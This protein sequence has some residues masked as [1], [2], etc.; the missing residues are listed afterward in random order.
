M[1]KLN[2]IIIIIGGCSMENII[3]EHY[4]T[5]VRKGL[6]QKYIESKCIEEFAEKFNNKLI[7]TLLYDLQDRGVKII[8][9]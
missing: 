1:I 9:S 5:I 4:N 7:K 3:K 2:K 6:D 8:W